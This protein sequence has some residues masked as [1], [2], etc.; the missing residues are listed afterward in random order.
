MASVMKPNSWIVRRT[1]RPHIAPGGDPNG[2]APLLLIDLL[3]DGPAGSQE[4]PKTPKDLQDT[5][6]GPALAPT[7]PQEASARR[8]K[9]LTVPR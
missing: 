9:P 1:W 3:Q 7:T 2:V 8:P 6:N 5:P 4:C